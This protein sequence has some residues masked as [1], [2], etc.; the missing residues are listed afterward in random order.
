MDAFCGLVT[1]GGM[2][3]GFVGLRIVFSS[4]ALVKIF[5]WAGVALGAAAFRYSASMYETTVE[6]NTLGSEF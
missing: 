3:T 2:L 1:N 5:C 4:G 6:V